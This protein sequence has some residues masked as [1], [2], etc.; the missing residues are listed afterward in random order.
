MYVGRRNSHS[1]ALFRVPWVDYS[2]FLAFVQNWP[3]L[4][5]LTTTQQSLSYTILSVLKPLIRSSMFTS[6]VSLIRGTKLAETLVN[7]VDFSTFKDIR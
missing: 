4:D 5:H 1:L 2:A 3:M 7:R 6:E